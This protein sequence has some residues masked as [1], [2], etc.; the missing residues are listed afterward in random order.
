MDVDCRTLKSKRMNGTGAQ[1]EHT[2]EQRG[3]PHNINISHTSMH[4]RECRHAELPTLSAKTPG[5]WYSIL[6]YGAQ[7]SRTMPLA[8]SS[9]DKGCRDIPIALNVPASPDGNT[10]WCED[11]VPSE[12]AG[13]AGPQSRGGRQWATRYIDRAR[14]HTHCRWV[15]PQIGLPMIMLSQRT[16][17]VSVLLAF[18]GQ[19][20]RHSK[21]TPNSPPEEGRP[22][23]HTHLIVIIHASH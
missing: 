3:F 10:A 8:T 12:Q 16:D 17:Q 19:Y 21:S 20:R 13:R 23:K 15:S 4:R 1:H 22:V 7:P 5:R 9:A 18:I 6:W 11:V 2:C 14:Y